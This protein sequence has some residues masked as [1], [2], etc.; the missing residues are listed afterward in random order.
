MTASASLIRNIVYKLILGQD[1]RS[2]VVALIDAQFLEYAIDFFKRVAEAKMRQQQI[3]VDWYQR[4]ML[5]TD[6]PKEQIARHAGLNIK[7]IN[8]MYNTTRREIVIQAAAEH[9]ETLY[10]AIRELTSETDVNI[11]LTV[12]FNNVAIDL[13]INESLIV[14]NALAVAR[15]AIRGSLWSTAG[16]QVEKPL[17]MTLCA[18]HEVPRS[19]YALKAQEGYDRE[20]DFYLIGGDGKY[21]RCEVKLMGKGNPESA[22]AAFARNANIF[23]AD[24]LSEKNKEQLKQRGILWMEL[25]NAKDLS[26]FADILRNLG[27]PHQSVAGNV[28]SRID[29]VLQEVFGAPELQASNVFM[30]RESTEEYT[31]DNLLDDCR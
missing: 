23:I 15:A 3:T 7:T 31:P 8:N 26:Q 13:D 10:Q 30:V 11:V 17:M 16:K 12:K 25:R 20:V 4:E 2:E 9:Y 24:K 21:Y 14:I 1:Y 19:H 22:D 18:L 27:I 28:E 6:L 29:S 5:A